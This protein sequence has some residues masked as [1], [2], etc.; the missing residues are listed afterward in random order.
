MKI[1]WLGEKVTLKVLKNSF[2]T[3]KQEQ[4]TVSFVLVDLFEESN[5]DTVTHSIKTFLDE[6]PDSKAFIVCSMFSNLLARYFENKAFSEE[7]IFNAFSQ[8]QKWFEFFQINRNR[9]I[10]IEDR[11][12]LNKQNLQNLQKEIGF[13]ELNLD[14]DSMNVSSSFAKLMASFW[15]SSNLH[16]QKFDE[17]L[18]LSSMYFHD[19]SQP[20][21][22]EQLHQA[23]ADLVS[24]KQELKT[25]QEEKEQN[26]TNYQALI[27]EQHSEVILQTKK[28]A[29]L[30]E[31]NAQH[32]LDL[33]TKSSEFENSIQDLNSEIA[34]YKLQ[35]KQLQEELEAQN[36][37]SNQVSV[38]AS[39][40]KQIV[41]TLSTEKGA[42]QAELEN[43]KKRIAEKRD[44][45]DPNNNYLLEQSKKDQE[46]INSYSSK[47]L[48]LEEQHSEL[49]IELNRCK[50]NQYNLQRQNSD[51]QA[52]E[53]KLNAANS[54]YKNELEL[55]RENLAVL[56]KSLAESEKL[57]SRIKLI[58]KKTI[59]AKYNGSWQYRRQIKG[60]VKQLIAKQLFD[61][62]WYIENYPFVTK[63]NI[64]PCTHYLLYGWIEGLNPSK[65]FDSHAY[66]SVNLDVAEKGINPLIHYM[67]WGLKEGRSPSPL[68]KKLPP[69]KL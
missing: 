16:M 58:T 9:L 50:N 28:V 56:D 53:L 33:T 36:T 49:N 23:V 60:Q 5:F 46:V 47:L 14:I 10:L 35:I 63:E 29:E 42:L 59:K 19:T 4:E 44:F 18:N 57:L 27:S 3:Q 52:K 2:E 45:L 65:V 54:E 32:K 61:T 37:I 1:I 21:P 41:D 26:I 11:F 25:A 67:T 51:L 30:E 69:P 12:V 64:D 7:K 38:D 62:K 6:T 39:N 43:S 40:L 24:L 48:K 15:L 22:A 55:T 17:K 13:P 66:L 31:I 34:L 8:L 20:Q 68:Q